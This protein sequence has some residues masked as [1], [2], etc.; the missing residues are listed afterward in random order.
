MMRIVNLLTRFWLKNS[1][2]YLPVRP[3]QRLIEVLRDLPSLVADRAVA[4]VGDDKVEGSMGIAGLKL[5]GSGRR[6]SIL[7]EGPDSSLSF[8]SRSSPLGIE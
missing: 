6:W 7:R 5:M 2:V 8:E 4:L 3:N 1:I